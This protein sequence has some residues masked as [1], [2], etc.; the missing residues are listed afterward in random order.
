DEPSAFTPNPARPASAIR[1]RL[2]PEE[3]A[4]PK[5]N[6]R[7]EDESEQLIVVDD[8]ELAEPAARRQMNVKKERCTFCSKS[9]QKSCTRREQPFTELVAA[10]ACKNRATASPGC[11][12]SP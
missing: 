7:T 11:A 8:G 5:K 4:P 10:K 9:S 12:F 1:R 6:P 2:S 3:S